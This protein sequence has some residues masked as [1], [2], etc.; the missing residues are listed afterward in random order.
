M[1]EKHLDLFL[2]TYKISKAWVDSIADSIGGTPTKIL[3]KKLVT[4]ANLI[5]YAFLIEYRGEDRLSIFLDI[6]K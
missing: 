3:N 4:I 1:Q 6:I 2:I 5:I